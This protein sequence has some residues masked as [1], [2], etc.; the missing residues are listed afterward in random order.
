MKAM[1]D[2]VMEYQDCLNHIADE[3]NLTD[4]IGTMNHLTNLLRIAQGIYCEAIVE[5]D[6]QRIS[7][8]S[9]MLENTSAI[10]VSMG[11]IMSQKQFDM[12]MVG[13]EIA[14]IL[15]SLKSSRNC[16]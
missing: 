7:S 11:E 14:P 1:R 10:I 16:N 13:A 15:S 12:A 9:S 5:K 6:S 2:L 4:C 8:A 3:R